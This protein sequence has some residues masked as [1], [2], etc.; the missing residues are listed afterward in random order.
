MAKS[1]RKSRSRR[2]RRGGFLGIDF[3]RLWPFGQKTEEVDAS[4]SGS[5]MSGATP[6]SNSLASNP[7]GV[8][9]GGR[10]RG[11]RHRKTRRAH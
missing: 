7:D 3:S 11:R 9:Q 10:H 4:A 8:T 2:T 6:P 5:N 1:S